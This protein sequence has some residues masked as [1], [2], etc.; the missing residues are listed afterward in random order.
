[1]QM[2]GSQCSA[3][4]VIGRYPAGAEVEVHYDPGN[5]SQAALENPTGASW[6]LL[7]IALFCFGVALYAS[8]IIR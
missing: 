4:K 7:G 8:H 3:E 1:M 6:I 2:S 5:P